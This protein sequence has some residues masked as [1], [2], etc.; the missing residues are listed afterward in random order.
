[1]PESVNHMRLVKQMA[2]WI[3]A[4]Y[5]DGDSGALL[6]DDPSST[7]GNKPPPLSGFV[8]DVYARVTSRDAVVVGEAKTATDLERAHTRNQL[9]AFL[10]EC[11]TSENGV[12]VVAV[13]WYISRLVKSLVR[14]LQRRNGLEAVATVILDKIG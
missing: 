7:G 5:L 2:D 13:P 14:S 11:S 1:M 3:S 9:T 10:K 6:V 4:E 8:P 12:L